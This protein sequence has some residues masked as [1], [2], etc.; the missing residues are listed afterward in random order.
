MITRLIAWWKP[1]QQIFSCQLPS[2]PRKHLRNHLCQSFWRAC[3]SCGSHIDWDVWRAALS[4]W[5]PVIG[6]WCRI[7]TFQL[8][9]WWF[10]SQQVWRRLLPLEGIDHQVREWFQ[11][12]CQRLVLHGRGTQDEF[13]GAWRWP[14]R[15]CLLKR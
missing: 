7:L 5:K 1:S 6:T 11:I 13:V 15:G 2:R 12:W 3:S 4:R 14:D 9:L 8:L 10:W